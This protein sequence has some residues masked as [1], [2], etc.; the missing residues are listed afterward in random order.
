MF[1]IQHVSM[2]IWNGKSSDCFETVMRCTSDSSLFNASAVT[3]NSWH[4]YDPIGTVLKHQGNIE[5]SHPSLSKRTLFGI[6]SGIEFN[7]T[8]FM[9]RDSADEIPEEPSLVA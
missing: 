1:V 9:K 2:D 8:E 4:L 3:I 6:A 7:L 5:I